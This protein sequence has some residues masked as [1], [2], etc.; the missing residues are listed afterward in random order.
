MEINTKALP[1]FQTLLF[2]VAQTALFDDFINAFA[3]HGIPYQLIGPQPFYAQDPCKSILH[4]LRTTFIDSQRFSGSNASSCNL[5]NDESSTSIL[6]ASGR[7]LSEI[8]ETAIPKEQ[9]SHDDYRR[10]TNL[11][12]QFNTDYNGF[13]HALITRQGIDDYDPRAEAVS[14]MTIHASKGLEFDVVF[15]PACEQGIIPFEL[16]GKK[17]GDE[18][19]E[20]ERLFYVGATRTRRYLYLTHTKKRT[21][22]GKSIA[23]QRS[24]LVDRIDETLLDHQKRKLKPTTATTQLDLF[25]V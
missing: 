10:L 14:L 13:F 5:I 4:D 22:R 7:P 19:Q 12:K 24:Y 20:E 8:I 2:C 18:L 15:I 6:F 17:E 3:N 9:L 11:A 16:F 25:D 21:I 1:A 23:S